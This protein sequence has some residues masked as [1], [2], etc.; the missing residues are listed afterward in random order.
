MELVVLP[1]SKGDCLLLRSGDGTA[2]LVDGGMKGSFRKEVSPQLRELVPNECL[3]LVCVSHID[4]DHI[5][6]IVAYFEMLA[7]EGD[8]S[9]SMPH[10]KELWHNNVSDQLG[11][12]LGAEVS[13]VL[14]SLKVLLD[15]DD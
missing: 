5:S 14:E 12:E 2:I 6:G 9:S 7:S 10:V 13:I 1:A 11:R 4:N 8:K 3:D 15:S